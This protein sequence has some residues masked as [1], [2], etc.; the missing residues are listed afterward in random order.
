MG[1]GVYTLHEV[2]FIAHAVPTRR[3]DGLDISGHGSAGRMTCAATRCDPAPKQGL[4]LQCIDGGPHAV[5]TPLVRWFTV[6][7]RAPARRMQFVCLWARFALPTHTDLENSKRRLGV[8][9][10]GWAAG[11]C[12]AALAY[13]LSSSS[14]VASRHSSWS[15]ARAVSEMRPS[16]IKLKSDGEGA[17]KGRGKVSAKECS[18]LRS[19]P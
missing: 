9:A 6:V 15:V 5:H 17:R 4:E 10:T 13:S 7:H 3:P 8:A 16:E 14:R 12:P 2:D 1:V 11:C 18:P 19:G